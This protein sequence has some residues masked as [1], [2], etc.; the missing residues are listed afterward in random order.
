MFPGISPGSSQISPASLADKQSSLS[1]SVPFL[2]KE[3]VLRALAAAT[4]AYGFSTQKLWRGVE[5][6]ASLDVFVVAGLTEMFQ[7]V[8]VALSTF[9]RWCSVPVGTTIDVMPKAGN[10]SDHASVLAQLRCVAH[11]VTRVRSVAVP[12][13]LWFA[14]TRA[15]SWWTSAT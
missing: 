11:T 8:E 7:S 9:A 6:R 5:F 12:C 10:A 3:L 2:H 4:E 1:S 15:A 13:C 14:V